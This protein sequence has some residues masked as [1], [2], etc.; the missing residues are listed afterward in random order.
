MLADPSIPLWI[1]ED[2]K[3]ADALASHGCCAVALIGVWNFKGRNAFGASTCLADWDDIALKHRNIRIVFDSDLMTKPQ[4][5]QALDRLTEHLQR[6]GAYVRAVYL[7]SENGQ[8]IAADDYLLTHPVQDLEGLLEAPRPQP[9][10]APPMIELLDEAPQA[11]AQALSLMNSMAYAVT[12]IPT[13]TTLTETLD[14]D[15]QVVTLTS[16]KI[17]AE[18]RLFVTRD[19]GTLFGDLSDPNVTSLSELGFTVAMPDRPREDVLWRGKGVTAYRAGIRPDVKATFEGIVS[20]YNHSLDFSRSLDEQP[21]MCRFSACG[22][23]MT[24]FVD[25]FTVLPY[26]WANSAAPGSGKTKWGHC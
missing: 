22:S 16:P 23:L 20:V 24:W 7:P 26:P 19:D 9:Q 11:M 6:K 4:V 14:K 17:T 18:W 3:K 5:R 10:P 15:G 1:I 13:K 25:A 2:Q 12:W 21:R 8:K